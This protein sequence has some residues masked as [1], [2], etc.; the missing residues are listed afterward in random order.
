M[1][2]PSDKIFH[3]AQYD[4]GWL[5]A[6]GVR[7]FIGLIIDTMIAA[8]L[9]DENRMS[10]ALNA[11]GKTYLQERKDETLLEEAAKEWGVNS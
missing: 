6:S 2:A 5:R 3:N 11:L 10:Y 9:I 4:I 8:P 7:A 1:Q